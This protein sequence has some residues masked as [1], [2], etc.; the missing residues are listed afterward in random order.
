MNRGISLYRTILAAIALHSIFANG[1][2]SQ[3]PSDE[4]SKPLAD[5]VS[6]Y[7]GEQG[8]HG[9]YYGYWDR[10]SDDDRKYNQAMDFRPLKHFGDDSITGISTRTEFTTGKIWYLQD[11]KYYTSLWAEGGHANSGKKLGNYAA[12]EHWAVRRW[13]SDVTASVTISGHVGK[14]MPWG[15]NWNGGCRALIVVDGK[16]VLSAEADEDEKD[17]SVDVKVEEGSFVD[18]LIGPGPSIGVIKFTATIAPEAPSK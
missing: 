6:E 1:C 18:F 12:T 3:S 10:T 4:T 14:V 2:F 5:S 17:F 11:G 8:L 9:W 7:S 16:Q 13:K 15:K